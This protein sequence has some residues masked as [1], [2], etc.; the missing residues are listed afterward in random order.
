M[1]TLILCRLHDRSATS[2][3]VGFFVEIAGNDRAGT[4]DNIFL[5]MLTD[6]ICGHKVV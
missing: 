4:K 1:D 2:E 6:L 5:E 3:A